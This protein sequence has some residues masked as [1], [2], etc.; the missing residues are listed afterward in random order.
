MQVGDPSVL[1]HT[2]SV[3][4]NV[5]CWTDLGNETCAGYPGTLGHIDVDA[6][7]SV[8]HFITSWFGK[9]KILT[10]TV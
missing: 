6:K 5:L 9:C 7:V 10:S 2:V 4:C 3:N 1:A 8:P